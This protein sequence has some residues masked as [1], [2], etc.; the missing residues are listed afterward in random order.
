MPPLSQ[1]LL[2]AD[3]AEMIR[4]VLPI[5]FVVIYGVAHLV[6]ALQEEK[7]KREKFPKREPLDPGRA[8][9]F[10]ADQQEQ[11][12][13]GLGKP[14]TLEETLRR[15][16][17][18]FLKRAQGGGATSQPP[19]TPRP[20]P[21][22]QPSAPPKKAA[23]EAKPRRLVKQPKPLSQRKSEEPV[24]EVVRP[25][26]PTGAAV[27]AYVE[28]QMR[29]VASIGRQASRLGSEVALADDR[30]EAQ[31][32]EKFDHR[33]GTLAPL[34]AS[35]T[36]PQGGGAEKENVAAREFRELIARPGGMR[37]LVIANEVL[38]RPEERW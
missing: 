20:A 17:E 22:R 16:V 38:R 6:G 12:E 28:S 30:M 15:E 24:L 36:G 23:A 31:L 19:R 33:V 34:A 13:P 3:F 25:G 35:S 5:I 10:P 32:H 27:D 1:Q 37:Q 14:A 2:L 11:N 8:E 4:V 29:G 21:Q 18:D 9:R 7:K 26:A